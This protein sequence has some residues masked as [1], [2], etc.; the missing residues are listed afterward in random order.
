MDISGGPGETLWRYW[1][2]LGRVFKE[3][4]QGISFPVGEHPQA[5]AVHGQDCRASAV[6]PLDA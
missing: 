2:N 4:R 6:F 5:Q 1:I 3:P